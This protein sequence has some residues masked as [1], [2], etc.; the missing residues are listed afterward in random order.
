MKC[1]KC[2]ITVKSGKGN[3]NYVTFGGK[4]IYCANCWNTYVEERAEKGIVSARTPG[5]ID[6]YQ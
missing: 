3:L 1:I 5:I 4:E 2:G 6:T